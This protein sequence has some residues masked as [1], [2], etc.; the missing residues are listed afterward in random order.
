MGPENKEHY[1]QQ[2]LIEQLLKNEP[3]GKCSRIQNIVPFSSGI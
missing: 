1:V 3:R 2:V